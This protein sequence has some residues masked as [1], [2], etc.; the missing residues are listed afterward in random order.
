MFTPYS[1]ECMGL[2]H[3]ENYLTFKWTEGNIFFSATR[4]GDGMSIHF[5]SDKPSLRNIKRALNEFVE[6]VF[7]CY[8][9]CTMVLGIIDLPSVCRIAEKCR[10]IHI[11]TVDDT[12]SHVYMRC[13][14][15]RVH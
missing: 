12:G 1:G 14:D 13:K 6:Y 9:W 2:S 10:F 7:D 15:D 5:A 8:S 3:N 11:G 4:V